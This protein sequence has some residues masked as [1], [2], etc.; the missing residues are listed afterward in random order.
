M[1][2]TWATND[3]PT[4]ADFNNL[5]ADPVT[6]DVTASESTSSTSYGA[7]TTAGPAVTLSLVSGQKC[8]VWV[9]FFGSNAIGAG[10]TAVMSFAVS[11]ASTLA[12][13]DVNAAMNDSSAGSLSVERLTVFTAGAS[14]STTFTSQYKTNGSGSSTFQNRRI[15]VLTR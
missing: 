13:S 8:L 14:G 1:Y 3:I 5:F 11:G 15:I 10:H 9:M 12:A 6:A 4:A 7:L 2:R